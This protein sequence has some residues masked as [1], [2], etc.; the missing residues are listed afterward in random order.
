MTGTPLLDVRNLSVAFDTPRGRLQAASDV[1][2]TVA[3]DETL[4]IVGESGCGKSVTLSAITGMLGAANAGI[5]GEALFGAT[6]MLTASRK[7]ARRILGKSIGMIFQ[8]PMTSLNPVLTIGY[9]LAEPLRLHTGLSRKARRA[10]AVELLAQVGLTDPEKRMGQY[11]HELS[12]GMRQRVTIAI[13][14]ACGPELIVADEPTTALDVTVQAQIL[15]LLTD[16]R[17]ASGASVVMITHDLGVVAAIADRVAVMYAGRIVETAPVATLFAAPAHPYTRALMA[18]VPD[19]TAA[20]GTPARA[21]RSWTVL[22]APSRRRAP[23]LAAGPRPVEVRRP[24]GP[25]ANVRP[26]PASMSA[27]PAAPLSFPEQVRED[28]RHAGANGNGR[29]PAGLA[30]RRLYFCDA[31]PAA[32]VCADRPAR[33]GGWRILPSA[34]AHAAQLPDDPARNAAPHAARKQGRSPSGMTVSWPACGNCD[35]L[36]PGSPRAAAGRCLRGSRVPCR[37]D[38][39][40]LRSSGRPPGCWTRDRLGLRDALPP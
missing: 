17:R 27:G 37:A 10:R 40:N 14:L 4:A 11:P 7:E 8:N 29:R 13:A 38:R 28:N 36:E 15:D 22:R 3:R 16:L 26:V 19:P 39:G 35:C 21:S 2:F 30:A 18:A 5:T 9:Q 1:S 25:A 32:A 33:R 20:A 6:D 34:R 12:G 31:V 24:G 23:D